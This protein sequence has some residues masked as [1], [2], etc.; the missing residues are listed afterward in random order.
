MNKA[1]LSTVL[2]SG[3]WAVA[4]AHAE[5]WGVVETGSYIGFIATYD[6]I[7]FEARF[8]SFEAKIEFSANDLDEASFDV[9]IDTGSLDSNSPDRDSGMKELDWFAVA[10][11]PVA[12]FRSIRFQRTAE[13]RYLAA[14]QLTLKDVS[15]TIEVPFT[16][17][18]ES[19]DKATLIAET[20][21]KRGDFNVGAGEWAEDDIIGFDVVVKARL[22]LNRR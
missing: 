13:T 8:Q 2:L 12:R 19:N 22:N 15:K 6:G 5:E 1:M 21:L 3:F 18:Q 20:R 9:R 7:P 16:W 14:G 11:Y 4:S 10:E 17:E